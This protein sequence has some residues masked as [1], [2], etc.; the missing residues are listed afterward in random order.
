MLLICVSYVST[1]NT[2]SLTALVNCFGLGF[3][4]CCLEIRTRLSSLTLVLTDGLLFPACSIRW[5]LGLPYLLGQ[6]LN[7]LVK[8]S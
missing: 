2:L 6:W 1:M 5:C 4:C 3:C 7:S 8:F